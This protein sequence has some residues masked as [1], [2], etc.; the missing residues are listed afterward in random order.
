M[1]NELMMTLS[2]MNIAARVI[3]LG[4][5]KPFLLVLSVVFIFFSFWTPDVSAL[6]DKNQLLYIY[7]TA[8]VDIN[9]ASDLRNILIPDQFPKSSLAKIFLE[10]SV[11]SV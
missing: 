3:F 5:M 8:A 10:S 11:M 9:K 2:A 6:R 4:V 7:Y 1:P